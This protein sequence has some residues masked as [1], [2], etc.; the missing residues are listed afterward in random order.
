MFIC[1]TKSIALLV[2]TST[3]QI[4][5]FRLAQHHHTLLSGMDIFA[6]IPRT[7]LASITYYLSPI[8]PK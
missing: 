8:K 5:C 6:T 7:S 1:Y 3:L 4:P 2:R